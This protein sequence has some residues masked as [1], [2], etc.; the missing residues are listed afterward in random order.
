MTHRMKDISAVVE[1][2]EA[3][4]AKHA[5]GGSIM[6]K[7]AALSAALAI[8]F[9]GCVTA[10]TCKKTNER[11]IEALFVRWNESLQTGE[12]GKVVA[13]YAEGSVLLPT[14]SNT[15]RRTAAEK[16]EYFRY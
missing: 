11:E 3:A 8:V 9:A 1:I 6:R 5:T 10:P 13:N 4:A 2:L 12:P 16:E 15:P 14:L 7:T